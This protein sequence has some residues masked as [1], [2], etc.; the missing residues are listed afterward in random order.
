[1]P[2]DEVVQVGHVG[3]HVVG[4]DDVG[5]GR[6]RRRSR[7]GQLDAEEPDQSSA[8]RRR[9]PPRPDRAPGRCRAPARR[10]RRSCAAGSRR[11]WRPRRRDEP[12]PRPRVA[13]KPSTW[14]RGMPAQLVGERR[15][16]GVVLDEDGRRRELVG[17]LHERAVRQN[18]R[19]SGYARRSPAQ[20]SGSTSALA[21]GVSPRSRNSRAH[22][23]RTTGNVRPVP[24]IT[25]H[26]STRARRRPGRWRSDGGP[27]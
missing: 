19:P 22:R 14:A 5:R 13:S 17:Q 3:H 24:P 26:P 27:A 10:R 1:M 11:C 2:A 16:V 25:A 20:S 8:R 18:T 21:I 4:D 12:D 9:R 23:H 7:R 6:A 15:V